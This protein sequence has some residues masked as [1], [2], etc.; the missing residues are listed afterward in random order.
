MPAWGGFGSMGAGRPGRTG[1]TVP[2]SK[3]R[4]VG[5][6]GERAGRPPRGLPSPWPSLPAAPAA[7]EDAARPGR[8]S[9]AGRGAPRAARPDWRGRWRHG[10]PPRERLGGGG[11]GGEEHIRASEQA[12]GGHIDIDLLPRYEMAHWPAMAAAS[13]RRRGGVRAGSE[14]TAGG[15]PAE[16]AADGLE[17]RGAVLFAGVL[18]AGVLGLGGPP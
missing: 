13:L 3:L 8:G 7:L 15:G 6:G 11:G 2:R 16:N 5:G 10:G 4:A 12:G 18:P 17:A 1:T 14:G 9:A